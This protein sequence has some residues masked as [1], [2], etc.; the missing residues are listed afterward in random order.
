MGIC[1][2][3]GALS[4]LLGAIFAKAFTAIV[5]QRGYYEGF[6]AGY[7]CGLESRKEVK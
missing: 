2:V 7:S 1:L 6:D 5:Y 3:I 4:F